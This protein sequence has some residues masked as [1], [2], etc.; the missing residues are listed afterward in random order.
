M[1]LFLSTY[2]IMEGTECTL[3]K[4]ADGGV[5]TLKSG[6]V[7]CLRTSDVKVDVHL[8]QGLVSHVAVLGLVLI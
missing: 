3:I 8:F 1:H 2:G 6:A 5:Y 4:I 7:V